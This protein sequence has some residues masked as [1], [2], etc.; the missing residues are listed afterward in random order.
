MRRRTSKMKSM[1]KTLCWLV[2]A[3]ALTIGMAACSSDADSIVEPT[4]QEPAPT[5]LHITVGAGIAN[6]NATTRDDVVKGTNSEI[7]PTH[8][9]VF[10]TGDRLYFYRYID[11]NCLTGMLTMD[12]EPTNDGL[13]ATFSGDVK[14]YD[15]YNEEITGYDYSS[16][17]NPLSGSKAYLIQ[18]GAA[19]GCFNE[20]NHMGF[21]F[22]ESYSIASD[23]NTLMKTALYVKGDYDGTQQRFNL[24]TN[25]API[26]N[27]ALGGLT[28]NTAYT[29][30][31]R[32][33]YNQEFYKYNVDVAEITYASTVTT[34]AGG[35]ARFAISGNNEEL[36]ENQYWVLQLSGGG[37]TWE[38]VIGQKTFEPKIYNLT[39][40]LGSACTFIV[41]FNGMGW[42]TEI[43]VSDGTNSKT[44]TDLTYDSGS[45][46]TMGLPIMSNKTLTITAKFRATAGGGI[47]TYV[48]TI[49]NAT[50]TAD[51]P[52]DLGKVTLTKQQ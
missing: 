33:A 29:V 46:V 13:S 40:I 19:S 38:C 34:D 50:I 51:G 21:D 24:T 47:S 9:L 11:G 22:N 45:E 16:I 10:T 39:R 43:T 17:D 7:T 5:S 31:L 49:P 3:A 26:L 52:N 32:M 12:G 35:N 41:N 30:K 44:L 18:S 20:A 25:K 2:V 36:T 15:N 4:I 42:L 27:C 23:V 28:P 8:T 37:E 6:D 48:G 1:K 14:M